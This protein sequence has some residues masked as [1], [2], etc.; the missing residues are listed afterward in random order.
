MGIF[1]RHK[2]NDDYN[3][4]SKGLNNSNLKASDRII[5]NQ[6]N[7]N[8]EEA[9]SYVKL[10]K[11][12]TPVILNFEKLDPPASNKLLAFLAGACFALDGK[13]VRI[14]NETYLFAKK[15]EFLDGSLAQFINNLPRG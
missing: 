6:L 2:K 9:A 4:A 8:D 1:S 7:D 11:N 12:G 5:M 10:I 3:E 14:N 13:T 15:S